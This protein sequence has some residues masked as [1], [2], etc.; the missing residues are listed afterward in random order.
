MAFRKCKYCE[1]RNIQFISS[2]WLGKTYYRVIC[3][4]CKNITGEYTSREG[5][6]KAWNE[7]N[8]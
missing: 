2:D 3:N 4:D 1:H 5:A 8:R 7:E 6:F